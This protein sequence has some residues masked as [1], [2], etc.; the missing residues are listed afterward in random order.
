MART[1]ADVAL[2]L[3]A[4]A[5]PDARSPI[6]LSEPGE[7]FARPLERDFRG[8]RIAWI[9]DLHLPFEPE[10][11]RVVDQQ[12][13][14]FEALGCIVEDAEPDFTDADE[15]FK[16]WR[17]WSFANNLQEEYRQHRDQLKDT[18]VW[19]I[20]AGLKLTGPELGEAEIKRTQLYQRVRS[21]M[22]RFEFFILPVSQ[23][24]PF[25]VA[26]HFVTEIG[27]VSMST[28]IDWMKSCYFITT[29]GHPALSVPAGFAV[30]G[31]PVGLQIVG[32]HRDDWGVL[33]LG[34]AFEQATG[35]GKQRP[36]IAGI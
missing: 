14:V 24:L 31:L 8:T 36:T 5:G 34:Y 1:V 35:F 23:V 3:S 9:K 18:V 28:Y 15:I 32:R 16:T 27:G 7:L 17:A 33:Q 6:S 13:S 12:R 25:D 26:Q 22:E 10:V 30:N 29:I 2:M 11:K 19:N 4:I 20:E 21:F